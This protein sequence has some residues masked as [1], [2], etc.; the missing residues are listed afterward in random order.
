[1]ETLP[2]AFPSRTIEG[3]VTKVE[4]PAFES[5]ASG[6]IAR[7]PGAPSLKPAVIVHAKAGDENSEYKSPN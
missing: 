3:V 1:M 5:N 4:Y 7:S 2:L 6:V